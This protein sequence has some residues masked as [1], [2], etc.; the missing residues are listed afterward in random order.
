MART[1]W[2]VCQKSC[3]EYC[4]THLQGSQ[5]VPYMRPSFQGWIFPFSDAAR[6][7]EIPIQPAFE[8]LFASLGS[9]LHRGRHFLGDTRCNRSVLN[10]LQAHGLSWGTP[11]ADSRNIER[12]FCPLQEL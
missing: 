5:A 2:P 11:H 3:S 1:S 6:R 4:S 9:R 7:M 12:P 10:V 8:G